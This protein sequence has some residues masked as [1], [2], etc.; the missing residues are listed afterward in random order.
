MSV[1]SR[2]TVALA[3]GTLAL[4]LALAVTLLR[5]T[6]PG[7]PQLA[8]WERPGRPGTYQCMFSTMGTDGSVQV[9]APDPDTARRMI[10]AAVTEINRA[11]MLMSA[12]RPDSEVSRLNRWGAEEQVR[13]SPDT[14]SV[15]NSAMEFWRLTGGAFDITYAPLRSVWRE[16][17]DWGRPP[18]E[19][20]LAAVLATVGCEKLVLEGDAARFATSGM[21]VDL[22]G[23]AKGYALD[24]AARALKE[25]GARAGIVDIGGDMNLLGR[26]ATGGSWHVQVRWPPGL[27]GEERIILRATDCA[28]TTS[29]DYERG[30]KIG[31]RWFSHIIDPRTGRPVVD[32]PSV[33][34]VA[35]DATTAD[36]LAT[37]LS[38]L[39][40]EEG[41]ALVDSLDRVECMIMVPGPEGTVARRMSAHFADLVEVP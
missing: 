5:H 36:A 14:L 4:L 35:P 37:A 39:G 19:A 26:P 30:F 9:S 38:V 16:A 22:G 2:A 13:L 11:E 24:I 12:Y 23:I 3:M 25:A 10:Q 18:D 33:T 29:G 21:Q 20:E 6:D 1:R 7:M 8:V 34:V 31:D 28:I 27:P 17:V 15:L 41:I 32:V 40:V